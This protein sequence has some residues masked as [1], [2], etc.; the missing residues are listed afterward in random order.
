LDGKAKTLDQESPLGAQK[1]ALPSLLIFFAKIFLA[2]IFLAEIFFAEIFFAEIF[3][4][5]IFLVRILLFL[6]LAKVVGSPP[7][8]FRPN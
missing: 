4:A 5:K 7:C 1:S 2:E 6:S 8:S 3:L